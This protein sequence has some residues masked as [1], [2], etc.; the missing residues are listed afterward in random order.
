MQF[1][2]C[3]GSNG[4]PQYRKRQRTPARLS[5]DRDSTSKNTHDAAKAVS[6]PSAGA[7]V[8]LG[9]CEHG[10]GLSAQTWTTREGVDH[11]HSHTHPHWLTSPVMLDRPQDGATCNSSRHGRSA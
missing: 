11:G 3:K 10:A 1:L 7:V 8:G 6:L 5:D 4:L 9:M 2:K